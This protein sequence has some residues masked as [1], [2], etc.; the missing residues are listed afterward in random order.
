MSVY[1][2][3]FRGFLSVRAARL[4]S[5]YFDAGSCACRPTHDQERCRRVLPSGGPWL[6]SVSTDRSLA[7]DSRHCLMDVPALNRC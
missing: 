3:T 1:T 2:V 7:M 6:L 5:A 4:L